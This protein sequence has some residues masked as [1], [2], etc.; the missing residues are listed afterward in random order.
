M[1]EGSE[2]ID[3]SLQAIVQ[4]QS[5][6]KELQIL[7]ESLKAKMKKLQEATGGQV[8]VKANYL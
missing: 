6:K 8:D 3:K 2:F 5:E 7:N 1:P 4:I